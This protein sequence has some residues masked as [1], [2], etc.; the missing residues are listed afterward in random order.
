[1]RE[2][3]QAKKVESFKASKT[4]SSSALRSKTPTK[5]LW[6]CV[7]KQQSVAMFS[8]EAEDIAATG[9]C[10]NILWIKSQLTG[11]AII[12][13]KVPITIQFYTK[14]TKL[15]DVRSRIILSKG[16]IEFHFIP[17]QYQLVDIFIKLLDKPS[18]KRL[19]DELGSGFPLLDMGKKFLPKELSGRASFLLANGINIDYANIFWEDIIIKLNKRHREK[20]VPYTRFLSL[21][22]MHKMKEGY[23]DG[24]LTLYPTQVFS[25]NN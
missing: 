10:T 24:E 1:K 9:C 8:A 16:D 2:A 3:I 25:V 19:I 21:L 17:T 18:F 13:E 23:G 12:Y 4:E 11:Y 15:I 20:V 22:M 6:L 14:K 7:N 5:R